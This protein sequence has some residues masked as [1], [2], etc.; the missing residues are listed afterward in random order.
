MWGRGIGHALWWLGL[1]W[2]LKNMQNLGNQGMRLQKNSRKL[3]GRERSLACAELT[4][5]IFQ[6]AGTWLPEKGK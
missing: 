5:D 1:C 4:G 3:E 6:W 2:A